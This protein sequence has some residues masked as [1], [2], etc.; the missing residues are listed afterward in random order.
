MKSITKYTAALYFSAASA[1]FAAPN[2]QFLF[3]TPA[4]G[5]APISNLTQGSGGGT[6]QYAYISQVGNNTLVGVQVGT[7]TKLGVIQE[8]STG[9]PA[10]T[11]GYTGRG[12][13]DATIYQRAANGNFTASGSSGNAANVDLVGTVPGKNN[14]KLFIDQI[15]FNN[16]AIVYSTE[17]VGQ[18]AASDNIRVTQFS[19]NAN[20]GNQ[21][22]YVS[23]NH[24][25]IN[26][27]QKGGN[28]ASFSVTGGGQSLN[29]TQ[30]NTANDASQANIVNATIIGAGLD[31]TQDG[32]NNYLELNMRGT[33]S[34]FGLFGW[35]VGDR[36][37]ARLVQS[38]AY[39][40]AAV[41]PNQIYQIGSSNTTTARQDN[42]H[43]SQFVS[44][45]NGIGN[46]ASVTQASN[47]NSA[48]VQQI[49][50][51]N[52][53]TISQTGTGG[54]ARII[55]NG[56]GKVATITQTGAGENITIV[57]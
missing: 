10:N 40:D 6:D 44:Y 1:A 8:N 4:A 3:Q 49:G 23:S 21:F 37:E 51:N 54:L 48:L 13:S 28:K 34:N 20:S 14:H 46:S 45:Q 12:N 41:G 43:N 39:L 57:Q 19:P 56:N 31:W 26:V 42:S 47:S 16:K 52:R 38:G 36:N 17:T 29:L 33:T 9:G 5:L 15:G 35:Q 7:G 27:L 50:N 53:G 55:Q 18:S 25:N 11:I 22:Q 2:Q 32:T 30:N 24:S